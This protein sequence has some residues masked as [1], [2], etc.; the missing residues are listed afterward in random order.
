MGPGSLNL[1]Q[2]PSSLLW[3]LQHRLDTEKADRTQA[4]ARVGALLDG[5]DGKCRI[6]ASV[7]LK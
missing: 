2:Y 3:F 7:L 1:Q 6:L 4:S 5:H